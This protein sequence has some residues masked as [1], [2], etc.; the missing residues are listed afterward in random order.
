MDSIITEIAGGNRLVTESNRDADAER[1]LLKEGYDVIETH[2]KWR[3]RYRS[4]VEKVDKGNLRERRVAA[5]TFVVMRN[6]EN[7]LNTLNEATIMNSLGPLAPSVMDI[8][9]IFFPNMIANL[10][11]EIQP[12]A[13]P[14]SSVLTVKPRYTNS[15][16]GVNAGDEVFKK[17]TDGNY[18]SDTV[19]WALGTGNAVATNF[20][21]T[22]TPAPIRPGT[23]RVYVNGA[24]IAADNGD[25]GFHGAALSTGT[26]N[27]T[28]GAISV[29]FGT[30][31]AAAAAIT[32]EYR[33]DYEI[34][35]D[36]LRGLD[37][38]LNLVPVNAKPHPL[39]LTWSVASQLA[40]QAQYSLDVESTLADLAAQ[41]IRKE[42]DWALVSRISNAA[43]AV[44]DLN[45]DA[46]VPNSG[47]ALTKKQHYQDW[48]LKL[49]RASS[50]IYNKNQRGNV[51]FVLAGINAADVISAQA[52]FIPEPTVVPIGA[53]KIGTLDGVVDVILDA[54]MDANTYVF[55]FRGMQLGDA[56][57]IIAEWI[58]IFVTPTWQS[59]NLQGQQGLLSM[60]DY[61][62]NNPDYY[63]K[64]TLSGYTA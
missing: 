11:A 61:L 33:Y 48:G 29:T 56:A 22:L 6:Q 42:R 55:G 8:V 31:P 21:A 16:G 2:P 14:N 30:A 7:Y 60:Y 38:G 25:G 19:T 43:T 28:S 27:Y 47:N 35:V 20:T 40:A 45:F 57:M 50:F 12:I 59:P 3:D 10:I 49:R 26:L 64:G 9:R 46:T 32:L 1:A 58:P 51:S 23:V 5:S 34:N 44:T 37:I 39:K 13:Q 15:G 18:A 36:N 53:Y 62:L 63:A 4:L 52:N 41:F 17:G 24:S 54:S